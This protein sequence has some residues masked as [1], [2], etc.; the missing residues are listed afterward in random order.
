M[1][2]KP[3]LPSM[4]LPHV[5]ARIFDTPL[6]IEHSKLVAILHVLGPRLGFDAPTLNAAAVGY[7]DPERHMEM[8]SKVT[9]AE[10]R[11][12]GYLVADGVAIIP[13]I[14][15]LVQR[16]DWMSAIS[17]MVSYNQI[18]RMFFAAQDDHAV[19][20]II[21]EYD[22]PGGEVA[23][24]FDTAD[25]LFDARKQGG[26]PVIAVA[27]EFAASAGYLL[28][29]TADEIVVP[30]T[31]AV[32]SVGVVA[33][34][35]DYSGAI[36]KRG[37]AVTFIYAGDHKVDGNPYEPL[38]DSVKAEWQAEIDHVYSLFV[39]TVARNLDIGADRVRG[40]QAA[41]FMGFKAVD[42]GL[43]TRVNSIS[44]ELSLS[45]E[46]AKN[47]QY[48]RP[49]LNQSSTKE[50]NMDAAQEAKIK[51]EAEAKVKAEHEAKAKAEA[52]AKAKA[53]AD[54]K[55]KADAEA[56]AKSDAA[57]NSTDQRA[58][59]KSITTCDEAKGREKLAQHFAFDTD[60]SVDAAKAALAASP[61]ASK[62]DEAMNGFTP[63]IQGQEVTEGT[64]RKLSSVAEIYAHHEAIYSGKRAA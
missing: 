41:M 46:R 55:A 54:A 26:K 4:R 2:D 30:R 18:E 28:A 56:K 64:P 15:T 61:K 29:S 23:G 6:L 47:P 9:R 53:E 37:I 31:G 1:S 10:K 17:G 22:T 7:A 14:G 8:L 20:E 59:I 44:N 13:V 57:A 50:I 11:D 35:Y 5:A 42:A 63:N 48:A 24:A 58:R 36:E 45:I 38:P 49:F 32:G 34:H 27:T 62:L 21:M 16:S 51:A 12:E 39:E 52:E 25:R 3:Q 19:R 40:T 43:A 33:A 60:L